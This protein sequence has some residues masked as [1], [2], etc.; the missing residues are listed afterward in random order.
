MKT[1]SIKLRV[2]LW[3]GLLMLLV[4]VVVF[5]FLFALSGSL[6]R[7]ET[8]QRLLRMVEYNAGNLMFDDG[9]LIIDDG[10]IAFSNGIY[11]LVYA[12]DGALLAGRLPPG[13]N[14]DVSFEDSEMR[15]FIFDGVTYHVYDRQIVYETNP[16]LWVRGVQQIDG[17]EGAGALLYA[18]LFSLILLAC[19][20]IG[21]GYLITRHAFRPIEDIR[22][23]A[24]DIN[25][26][27]DLSQRISIGEL[28][29][30]GEGHDE[31]HRL[32]KTFNRMLA[33]LED[34]FEFEKQFISD[35][36]HELRTPTAVIL[37][38]C[39]DALAQPADADNLREALEVVHR[40]AEKLSRLNAQLLAFTRLE[41]SIETAQM[42]Q[43]DLSELLETLCAEMQLLYP[44]LQTD[45]HPG[46]TVNADRDLLIRLIVN[47]L[48][49]A[50]QHGKPGGHCWLTLRQEGTTALL[51]IK[52]DGI[53]I[54]PEHL[55]KIWNR[56]YQVNP[57][58]SNGEHNGAGLGLA[59]CRQI[60]ALH[61]GEITAVS[62]LGQGSEF[63][64]SMPAF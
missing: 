44:G 45:I 18:V 59:M 17:T 1:M 20:S 22:R 38:Q 54:A 52:D 43:L 25:V 36:S 37:A 2:T 42:E 31:L 64:S 27:R 49:N 47:L 51:V 5:V 8:R 41:R 6:A 48:Q 15:P 39:D 46:I 34:S 10:Y 16:T 14:I 28:I 40:Q 30:L 63:H 33:R 4:V 23:A 61:G 29:A 57:A 60:A 58:R 21:I 62:E 26:G 32:A 55:T 3:Y 50:F 53:G 24:D 13:V 35:A 9:I 12:E 11:T 56:F 7:N 19:L